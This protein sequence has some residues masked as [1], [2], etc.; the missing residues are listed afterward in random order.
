MRVPHSS[1]LDSLKSTTYGVTRLSYPDEFDLHLEIV[2]RTVQSPGYKI[3]NRTNSST[4]QLFNFS[5]RQHRIGL[6]AFTTAPRGCPTA[7]DWILADQPPM[8][9]PGT[10]IQ[11]YYILIFCGSPGTAIQK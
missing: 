9:S 6:L 11:K 1:G 10:A 4:F 3:P 5:T 2:A 7:E 8:G